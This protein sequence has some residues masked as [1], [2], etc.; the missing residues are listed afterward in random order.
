MEDTN[1]AAGIRGRIRSAARL[2]C[3]QR[4]GIPPDV[5]RDARLTGICFAGSAASTRARAGTAVRLLISVIS[6]GSYGVEPHRG[7][8]V[9]IGPPPRVPR[10]VGLGF[11]LYE[12]PVDRPDV[13]AA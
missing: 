9:D 5:Q 1:T 10:P 4:R 8:P 2:R 7:L 6:F 3:R 12:P 13:C 11:S